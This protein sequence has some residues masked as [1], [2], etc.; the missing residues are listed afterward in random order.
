VFFRSIL[1][2][3]F[4][5]PATS[6]SGIREDLAD[7][8]NERAD[9]TGDGGMALAWGPAGGMRQGRCRSGYRALVAQLL[10]QAM[11]WRW[12]S[13][14]AAGEAAAGSRWRHERGHPPLMGW[15]SNALGSSL[16]E[17]GATVLLNKA[18]GIGRRHS[19]RNHGAHGS[20]QL[21]HE[22]QDDHDQA[23]PR[24]EPVA[25]F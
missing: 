15:P 3:W 14:A 4:G 23:Y 18:E 16:T 12:P 22:A 11:P 17:D 9:H 24:H 1:S 21:Q 25:P 13:G 5:S 20:R 8:A 7:F 19:Q 10:R 2:H 6:R